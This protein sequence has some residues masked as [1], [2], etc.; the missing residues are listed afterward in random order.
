[1]LVH[2]RKAKLTPSELQQVY[3]LVARSSIEFCAA[4]YHPMLNIGQ[5]ERLENLQKKA[6]RLIYGFDIPYPELLEIA[7]LTPLKDRREKRCLDFAEKC[8]D[9]PRFSGWFPENDLPHEHDLRNTKK[10]KE[11]FTSREKRKNRPLFFMR[12]ELNKK[13]AA[14]PN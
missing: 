6:L 10:F 7:D 3:C 13:F 4:T 11:K 1:M 9:S 12:R 5:T 14:V 8:L 2:L